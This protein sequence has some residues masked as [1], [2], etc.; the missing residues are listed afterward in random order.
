MAKT[1][2]KL[3]A[4]LS[5]DVVGYSRLMHDDEAATVATLQEYRAAIGRVIDQHSGRVVNAP[6][7]NILAEFH[8]AVEA[9][10]AA[11]EMQRNIEGRNVELPEHRRMY[12][13]IG[14]N[15][16]DVLEE[17]DGTIYGDGVNIAARME[18]LA[19]EGG[20][21]I[22][23]PVHDAVEGKVK[24]G[25]EFLGEQQVK[26][27]DKPINVYRVRPD[28]NTQVAGPRGSKGKTR[29]TMAIIASVSA[30]VLVI[31][32]V[33]V[34]QITRSDVVPDSQSANGQIE[35]KT[36]YNTIAVLPIQTTGD[37]QEQLNLA[38]GLTQDISGG[39]TRSGK[40]LHIVTI[41]EKPEDLSK[42]AN[43][44][45][46]R[47]ILTG[48][49]RKSGAMIRVSVN[50]IDA[51]SMAAV[52]SENYDRELT[53]TNLF[54]LQDA[55]VTSIV[56]ELVG[57]G[58]VLAREVARNV[59]SQGTQ[60]LTAYA[61]VNF[62]RGQFFKVLSADL[63]ERSIDCLR[64]AVKDDPEYKE[65]W[66]LLAQL[67]TWGYSLYG[68]FERSILLE[69]S[70]AVDNAI[71]IDKDYARAYASKAEIELINRK[72]EDTYIHGEKAVALAH[73]DAGTIGII[74][75]LFALAGFGC[76]SPDELL[77]KYGYDRSV[78]CKRAER[79]YE[80]AKI[81]NRLDVGNVHSY[82]NYGLGNYFW[83]RR[84]WKE[85]LAEFEK[86]PNPEFLWWN[87]LMGLS[88]YGIG[89]KE[90]ARRIFAKIHS[91]AGPNSLARLQ[92]EGKITNYEIFLEENRHIYIEMGL[93]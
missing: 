91:L 79:G 4:I 62:V 77:E 87:H 72:F 14:V 56:D 92:H 52:W 68:S 37:D 51:E 64:Q 83:E 61:C 17:E 55:V 19:E 63:H 5:A 38:I 39:L 67:L 40:Q 2:R 93:Q 58:A 65:A 6:G 88:Y 78:A 34:W 90:N 22:A 45:R 12:F 57:N 30:V 41:S 31:V 82:D 89:D 1:K 27:I 44:M 53:A 70:V 74:S 50:L 16:G 25:F 47:Y 11:L 13:R 15:L 33:V 80:L 18:T 48:N 42:I 81:A 3:A 28:P 60:N 43:T 46:A 54:D 36:E 9:V 66:Q 85:L 71:R 8:S 10:Q 75:Y 73:N 26:N 21:C 32:G 86:I 35:N 69:A 84:M 29:P 24:C 7:D 49:L 76:S 20:I 23:S 59:M